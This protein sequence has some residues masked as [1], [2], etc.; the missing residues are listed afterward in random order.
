[1][2]DLRMDPLLLTAGER[3]RRIRQLDAAVCEARDLIARGRPDEA[4]GVLDDASNP[5]HR[6]DRS[7]TAAAVG[8][9]AAP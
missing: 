5:T 1:M 2:T 6:E 3:V 7:A 9:I 8:R 4:L